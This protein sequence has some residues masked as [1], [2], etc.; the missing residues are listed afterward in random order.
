MM[1]NL[2]ERPAIK[3]GETQEEYEERLGFW[4]NRIG[5][6]K[7]LRGVKE[8]NSKTENDADMAINTDKD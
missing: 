6:L 8:V 1:S 5:R 7:N 2:P 3:N 4:M